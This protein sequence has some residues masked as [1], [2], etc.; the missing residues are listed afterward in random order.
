[1]AIYIVTG[2]LGTGKT[3][4]CV[5]KIQLAMRQGKR[6][7]TNVNLNLEHITPPNSRAS[8]LRLPDKP[9]V[10]DFEAIGMGNESYDEEKNGVIVLDELGSWINARTFNDPARQPVLNWLVHSRKKGWDCFFICQNIA[11]VDKQLRETLAEYV[12]RCSRLDKVKIPIVSNLVKLLSFGQVDMTLPRMHVAVV[13]LGHAIDGMVMDRWFYRASD[14]FKAY[15]TRQVF[16]GPV[17]VKGVLTPN[18]G[19]H[20]ILPAWHVKGRYLKPQL[21]LWRRFATWWT[22]PRRQL[23]AAARTPQKRCSPLM[24]LPPDIRWTA[25]RR[26]VGQ[27]RL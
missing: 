19:L 7:A 13:R 11:Q 23:L 6:I 27:G 15:D 20:S 16:V 1:M 17:P 21:S 22:E 4:S 26:L 8:V 5:R 24:S 12:V 2:K 25:A 9:T 18:E 10:E 14:L 3:L